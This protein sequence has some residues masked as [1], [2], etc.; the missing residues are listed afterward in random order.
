MPSPAV[1]PE[2]FQ[3]PS[4]LYPPRHSK[5]R[6]KRLLSPFRSKPAQSAK[7]P[8]PIPKTPVDPP[9]LPPLKSAPPLTQTIFPTIS[10]PSITS[11]GGRSDFSHSTTNAPARRAPFSAGPGKRQARRSATEA[12]V[13]G[14]LPPT[15]APG[16][17]SDRPTRRVTFGSFMSPLSGGSSTGGW[18]FLPSFLSP[19]MSRTSTIES[20]E[21]S[22]S[23]PTPPIVHRRGDVECMEYNTLDDRRMRRLEGRSD[24]RP[25]FGSFVAYF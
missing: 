25:V 16:S 7:Y 5:H 1:S 14:A 22:L 20:D 13:L 6:F 23:P 9:Y 18:R 3:D 8:T 12:P 17:S 10:R 4:L 19:T 11:D 24:H 21:G 2:P 15:S